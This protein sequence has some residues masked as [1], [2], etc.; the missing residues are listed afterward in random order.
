G[1]LSNQIEFG[2]HALV[3]D[4]KRPEEFAAMLNMPM[5][6]PWLRETLSVEGARFARRV[7]GWTGIARRTLQVFDHFKGRY[8]DLQ[9]D[10]LVAL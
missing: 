1:G 3:A 6:Y 10:E 4:P 5:Q 2:R 8:D 7:F 9:S